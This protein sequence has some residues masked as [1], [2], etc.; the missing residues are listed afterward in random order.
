MKFNIVMS[1]AFSQPIEEKQPKGLT[2]NN[3]DDESRDMSVW[4]HPDMDMNAGLSLNLDQASRQV[5]AYLAKNPFEILGGE[6]KGDEWFKVKA[7]LKA[8]DLSVVERQD[9]QYVRIQATINGGVEIKQGSFTVDIGLY[10]EAGIDVLKIE[11][12][13]TSSHRI[14]RVVL[15]GTKLGWAGAGW[16]S[17]IPTATIARIGSWMGFEICTRLVVKTF[18]MDKY[19]DGIALP[20]PA[21]SQLF[22]KGFPKNGLAFIYAKTE[23]GAERSGKG[24]SQWAQTRKALASVGLDSGYLLSSVARLLGDFVSKYGAAKKIDSRTIEIER[25]QSGSS[26][27]KRYRLHT[28]IDSLSVEGYEFS[29]VEMNLYIGLNTEGNLSVRVRAK[30]GYKSIHFDTGLTVTLSADKPKDGVQNLKID[31]HTDFANVSL[32]W[33]LKLVGFLTRGIGALILMWVIEKLAEVVG[34]KLIDN[35]GTMTFPN[36]YAQYAYLDDIGKSDREWWIG[37]NLFAGDLKA[38]LPESENHLNEVMV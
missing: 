18:E 7:T 28:T 14:F 10:A 27:L 3:W 29:D 13:D 37:A 35:Y 36:A 31:T 9:K 5:N 30:G 38:V 22:L 1:E 2:A 32:P 17:A 25:K 21:A 12:S 23:E 4:T 34:K 15:D 8:V 26:T 16:I 20:L 33:W 24:L 6:E 19:Y 11:Q